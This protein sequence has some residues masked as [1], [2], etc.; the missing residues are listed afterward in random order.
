MSALTSLDQEPER[1]PLT[2]LR[3]VV[4]ARREL[5][6]REATLVRQARNAGFAWEHIA[7]ALDVTRQ[8]VHK[9]HAAGLRHRA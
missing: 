7:T 1:N 5:E 9:K 6:R 8:A 3:H 4:T 2:E